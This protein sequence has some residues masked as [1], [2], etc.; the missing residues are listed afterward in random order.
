MDELLDSMWREQ[1]GEEA[2][3]PSEST[4]SSS[5][6]SD[7]ADSDGF[8]EEQAEAE[9][10]AA[11]PSAAAAAA[12]D[13]P[14]T[15]PQHQLWR[16]AVQPGRA[17]LRHVR[18]LEKAAG[19]RAKSS[20][21][22]AASSS[23]P[24]LLVDLGAELQRHKAMSTLTCFFLNRVNRS[25]DLDLRIPPFERWAAS[26]RRVDGQGGSSDPILPDPRVQ[27]AQAVAGRRLLRREL[28]ESGAGKQEAGRLLE[29]V[30]K[31][32]VKLLGQLHRSVTVGGAGSNSSSVVGDAG[33]KVALEARKGRYLLQYKGVALACNAAHYDK[34]RALFDRCV[35]VCAC[36]C[37]SA[38]VG[39]VAE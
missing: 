26:Q 31:M 10:E 20:A 38:S 9:T 35:C 25:L 4:S 5:S 27:E 34:L 19:G 32:A 7:E 37:V 30:D 11:E 22:A 8:E 3:A 18:R 14:H 6:S 28:L 16:A 24:S 2:A 33:V 17:V 29:H 39:V 23:S 13:T 21:A 1:L 15:T 36:A 12:A